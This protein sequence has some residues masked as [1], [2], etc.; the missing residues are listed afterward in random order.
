ML[1]VESNNSSVVTVS[2]LSQSAGTGSVQLNYVG[3][4]STTVSF[5]DGSTEKASVTVTVATSSVTI[6]GM[7]SSK[8]LANNSTF[9]LEGLISVEA[10]GSCSNDIAWSS[11][12]GSIVSVNASGVVTSL[13]LGSAVITATP[14]DYP[15]AAVSCTVIVTKAVGATFGVG[16][17]EGTTA[18]ESGDDI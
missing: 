16:L 1:T 17:S 10:T 6:S 18:A 11:S 13:S 5:K 2:D 8:I 9:N 4:G 14:D 3:A 7:P 15:E 12:N